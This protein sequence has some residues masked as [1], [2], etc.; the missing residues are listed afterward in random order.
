MPSKRYSFVRGLPPLMRGRTEFGGRATPRRDGGEHDEQAT[1]Q[2]QLHDLFVLD[3]GPEARGLDSHHRGICDD[4]HLFLNASDAE[5][6]ID[7]CF[8]AG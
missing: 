1:V 7:A 6:E 5:I 3:D 8:L 4:R 2:R